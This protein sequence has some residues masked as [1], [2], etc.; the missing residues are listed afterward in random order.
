M[1]PNEIKELLDKIKSSDVSVRR[2]AQKTGIPEGRIYNW[3]NKDVHPK[4]EDV[5]KLKEY[6]AAP[7]NVTAEEKPVYD[8]GQPVSLRDQ[9]RAL[10]ASVSI[11]L[12]EVASLKSVQTGEPVGSILLRL[13][14]ACADA[15]QLL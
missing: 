8:E 6:F 5:Q 4:Y 10:S 15:G 9:V 11:L 14:K 7:A 13:Q 12:G 2:I 3:L 1:L